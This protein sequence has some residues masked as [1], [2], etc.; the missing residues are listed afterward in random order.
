MNVVQRWRG[1]IGGTRFLNKSSCTLSEAFY[2]HFAESLR[3]GHHGQFFIR[4]QEQL[5]WTFGVSLVANAPMWPSFCP[6]RQLTCTV[7]CENSD[8]MKNEW[9]QDVLFGLAHAACL[10]ADLFCGHAEGNSSLR[11]TEPERRCSSARNM[12]VAYAAHS[13]QGL[14]RTPVVPQQTAQT[15]LAEHFAHR[16]ICIHRG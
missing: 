13:R 10:S 3:S 12:D 14:S 4:S 5:A 11:R 15:F 2:A 16:L 8:A 6:I 7:Q 1:T 9:F